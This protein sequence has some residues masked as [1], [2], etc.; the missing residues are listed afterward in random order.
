MTY[1]RTT[2]KDDKETFDSTSCSD[3]PGH[4]DEEDNS[5][6]VLDARQEHPHDGSQVGLDNRLRIWILRARWN[7][8]RIICQS[9]DGRCNPWSFRYVLLNRKA[10]V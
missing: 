1:N 4:T 6:N 7:S 5:E 10:E 9:A 3:N 2:Y 8:C